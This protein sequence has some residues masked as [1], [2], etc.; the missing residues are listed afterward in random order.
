MKYI[1]ERKHNPFGEW[2]R[3]KI[4]TNLKRAEQSLEMLNKHRFSLY[5]DSEYEQ[6]RLV[7][8]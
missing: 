8:K 7:T 4:F 3:H 2:Q 5:K 1:I 6:Y